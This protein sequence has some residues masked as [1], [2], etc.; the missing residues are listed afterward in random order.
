MAIGDVVFASTVNTNQTVS[1]Q[2]SGSSVYMITIISAYNDGTHTAGANLV[3]TTQS[4]NSVM[5]LN[6][7]SNRVPVLVQGKI[8][9]SNSLYLQIWD[10]N[11]GIGNNVICSG[12]QV[13]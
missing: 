7:S 8:F 13:R 10:S 11:N 4:N 6:T 3:D 5:I 9:I 2:P 12:I 1:V